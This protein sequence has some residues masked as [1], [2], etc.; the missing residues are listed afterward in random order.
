MPTVTQQVLIEVTPH[1]LTLVGVRRH[2]GVLD[3]S[4]R[5]SSTTEEVTT[6]AA[7]CEID[8][9]LMG[10][11]EHTRRDDAVTRPEADDVEHLMRRQERHS[12]ATWRGVFVLGG[13]REVVVNFPVERSVNGITPGSHTAWVDG[14]KCDRAVLAVTLNLSI[15]VSGVGN[16]RDGQFPKGKG[17]H[18]GVGLIGQEHLSRGVKCLFFLLAT[19]PVDGSR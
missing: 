3:G 15:E 1:F 7:S 19:L 14:P 5:N 18:L 8:R 9:D 17:V 10:T 12:P 4:R 2:V 11:R 16:P 13:I 6:V